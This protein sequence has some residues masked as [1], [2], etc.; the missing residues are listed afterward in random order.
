MKKTL[1]FLTILIVLSSIS[2]AQ[3]RYIT[4]GA[5][6][7]EFYYTGDWYGIYGPMGSYDTLRTAIYRF[8][9]NGKKLTI[10]Y[11]VDYFIDGY[12]EPG[13]VMQ[14]QYILADATP[15]ILYNYRRYSKNNYTHTQLWTSFD[16]GENWMLREE[17]MGSADYLSASNVEG[18]IY[19]ALS[20]GANV[21]TY[22]SYDYAET[23]T[24]IDN[25][26]LNVNESGFSGCEFFTLSVSGLYHTY[27]C[28]QNYTYI[29]ISS[30]FISGHVSGV[31][32]DVFRGGLPGEVYIT[33]RFPG[34]IHRVS[35]SADTGRTFRHVYIHQYNHNA[36]RPIF[37]SDREP[38]V[39]YILRLLRME[40][41]NPRGYHRKLCVEYY[42]D[43]GET[44]VDV[45][46]HDVHKNY[47]Y[48]EAVCDSED[49][50]YL[51]S[52]VNDNSVQ[53][54][55]SNSADDELIRGYY[56]FRGNVRI[57]SQLLTNTTYL[58]ENLPNGE[59]EYYVVTYYQNGCLPDTSNYVMATVLTCRAVNDLASEKLTENSVLLIWS[60]P[61]EDVGVEGYSVYR[62]DT[63][64]TEV[65][66]LDTSY[67][68]ENLL[69]GDYVYYV[70]A[71]YT[72]GCLSDSS[73]HVW[74][75]VYLGVNE[76]EMLERVN[77]YPNPVFTTTVTIDANNFSKVEIY[78]FVG[79]LMGVK[80]TK[81]ID[82]SSYNAGIYFFKIFDNNN[83]TVIKRIVVL[84]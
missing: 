9:E 28:F 84:R 33:S 43:Y 58:D 74:E 16:Y 39:F 53:L 47:E 3:D 63:L 51:E 50:T 44:L 80:S 31:D 56:V 59:Y 52:N 23:F 1:L 69:V 6:P 62:N 12:T 66:V 5:E 34:D 71:H 81:T 20:I 35:F 24:L 7:G 22:C 65:F 73:N 13:S 83:N 78:N 60:T 26:K 45:Y 49:I 14:P 75:T 54:Q 4:R 55:W 18:L 68:D 30:E 67:L 40:D 21:G 38:G 19:R 82:V 8:T 25:R 42:R 57:T 32:P 11:D 61:E 41:L 46:C 2:H 72:N 64:L 37:M 17:N 48:Q 36:S 70:V 76:M 10:Q 79:Q 27:D 29:S 77:V 15:G